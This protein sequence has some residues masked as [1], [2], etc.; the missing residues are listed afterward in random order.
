MVEPTNEPI[1]E[2]QHIQADVRELRRPE[3]NEAHTFLQH[4]TPRILVGTR[5]QYRGSGEPRMMAASSAEASAVRLASWITAVNVV[6]ASGFSLAGLVSPESI[7]PAHSVPTQASFIFA[8]YAAARTIPLALISLWAIYERS[9]SAL[10]I[11]GILAGSVQL[12]DSFVGLYQH[13]LGKSIGPF[14]ICCLQFY[15]VLVLTRSTREF[16]AGPHART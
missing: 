12:L 7:L 1:P 10:I 5:T 4:G 2:V 15:A 11:L 13:D 9:V 8:M 6:V 3:R 14:I 16:G